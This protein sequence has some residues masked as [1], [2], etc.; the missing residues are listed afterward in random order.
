M[1]SKNRAMG[2]P[3]TLVAEDMGDSPQRINRLRAEAA[4]KAL[5][6][7]AVVGNG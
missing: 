7:P 5:T 2:Y 1:G 4:A 3:L 6:A